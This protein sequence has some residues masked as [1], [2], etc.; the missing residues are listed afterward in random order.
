MTAAYQGRRE[1]RMTS[2]S[3]AFEGAA[4]APGA[5]TRRCAKTALVEVLL[6]P[7]SRAPPRKP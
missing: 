5:W 3:K 2:L 7:P 6:Q 4:T 1:Q